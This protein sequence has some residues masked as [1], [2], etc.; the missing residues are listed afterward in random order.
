[1][2]ALIYIIGSG[3]ILWLLF[4]FAKHLFFKVLLILL[5]AA[6]AVFGLYYFQVGPFKDHITHISVIKAKYCSGKTPEICSCIVQ[7]LEADIQ[8]RFTP[9]EIEAM[10]A[11]RLESAYVYQRSMAQISDDAKSCLR[12]SEKE[13]LWSTFIKETLQ[14]NNSL[15]DKI[16]DLL[17]EGKTLVDEKINEVKGKKEDL[18]RRY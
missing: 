10:K 14:I 4:K 5:L 7:K 8:A 16:E 17:K 12:Q 3:I 1:M 2:E 13:E 15:T 9:E 6:V 18:D 11:D